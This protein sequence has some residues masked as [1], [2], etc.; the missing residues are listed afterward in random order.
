MNLRAAAAEFI[1]TFALIFV[2]LIAASM[3]TLG[4]SANSSSA[5]LAVALA[6]GLVIAVMASATG[7][8]SGGHIN[9]AVTFAMMATRR[10]SVGLGLVYWVAQLSG[11]WL[12]A[13]VARICDTP[14]AGGF[15]A[16]Y[17]VPALHASTPIGTGILIEA[18]ATFF[19][20]FV[21]FGT[22]VD[23]RAHK[24]GGLFIG[25]TVALDILWCGPLT[26]AAMNPARWFGPAAV[27][28]NF[29]N[30]IVW[31]AGPLLGALA[32]ALA[33]GALMENKP[34][35]APENAVRVD[36]ESSV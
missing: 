34:L 10:M 1:A 16:G 15:G 27:G 35:L 19:L 2:G 22:A 12:G 20:V 31:I 36:Q 23:P 13:F 4:D 11:A 28:N 3:T 17:G 8:I 5:L 26:G 30:S 18:I 24:V 7:A 32:A 14:H 21:I 29:A 25:L 33:Y 9:P 6:H